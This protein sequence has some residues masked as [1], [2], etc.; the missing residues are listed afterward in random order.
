MSNGIINVNAELKRLLK[1]AVMT[2]AAAPLR[3]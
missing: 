2:Y 1:K 3:N